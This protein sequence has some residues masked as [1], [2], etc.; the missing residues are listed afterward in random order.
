MWQLVDNISS[1]L[2]AVDVVTVATQDVVDTLHDHFKA[3]RLA[4]KRWETTAGIA[5]RFYII[6]I[7]VTSVLMVI[8]IMRSLCFCPSAAHSLFKQSVLNGH[9]SYTATNFGPLGDRLR[10]ILLC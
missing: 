4:Q 9:L 1:R 7:T 8:C 2:S 3:I 5:Y 10:H 6:K